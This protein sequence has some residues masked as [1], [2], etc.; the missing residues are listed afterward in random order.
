MEELGFEQ[1]LMSSI[2]KSRVENN[3]LHVEDDTKYI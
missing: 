3:V 2:W 1:R